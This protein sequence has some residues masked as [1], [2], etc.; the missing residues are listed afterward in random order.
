MTD[1]IWDYKVLKSPHIMKSRCGCAS[2]IK[3]TTQIKCCSF[4]ETDRLKIF[5]RFWKMVWKEKKVFITENII[6]M[7]TKRS[8]QCSK[9]LPSRRSQTIYYYLTRSHERIRVCQKFFENTLSIGKNLARNWKLQHSCVSQ[10]SN[11]DV[12]EN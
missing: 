7:P 1:N 11:L 12:V 6:M 2:S 5:N 3:G 4:S 8:R 10:Q 9:D